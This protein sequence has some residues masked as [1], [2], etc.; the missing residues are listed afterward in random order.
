MPFETAGAVPRTAFRR[1]TRGLRTLRGAVIVSAILLASAHARASAGVDG[2]QAVQSHDEGV[3]R[4]AVT[5][6]QEDGLAL[7]ACRGRIGDNVHVGRRRSD[8]S[9]CHVGYSGREIEIEAHELLTGVWR[10]A[11]AGGV[12][13]LSLNSGQELEGMADAPLAVAVLHPCRARHQGGVHIGQMRAGSAGCVFGYGGRPITAAEYEVLQAMSWMSWVTATPRTLAAG[14]MV[15]GVEG[16][17]PVFV[18]RAAD[19]GGLRPGKVMRNSAGC[20]VVSRGREVQVARFEVLV[21]RWVR[22][23]SGVMPVAAMP[24]GRENG[25]VQYTCRGHAGGA[26]QIGKAGAGLSG[27]HIGVQGREVVVR[28]FEVLGQ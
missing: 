16:G 18:C 19:A 23:S 5:I 1:G 14:A 21:P 24:S 3:P 7:Y 27:C 6:S 10:G 22:V 26:V 11:S 4:D 9:K 28:D 25:A 8:F 13:T 17:E 12:P 20:N 2:W 15:G